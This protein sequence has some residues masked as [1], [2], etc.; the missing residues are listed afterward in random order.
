MK[1]RAQLS[2]AL[3]FVAARRLRLGALTRE[4]AGLEEGRPAT[5]AGGL[6]GGLPER[7]GTVAVR[8]DENGLPAP[9]KAHGG[10][11]LLREG[12]REEAGL[13]RG[14]RDA[15]PPLPEGLAVFAPAQESGDDS[16]GVLGI[17]VEGLDDVAQRGDCRSAP[18]SRSAS[19][20]P[21]CDI[22]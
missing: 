19:Q 17:L 11:A 15:A 9:A 6:A 5:A 3:V 8:R 10:A 21:G 7:L 2:R 20:A 22:L 12:G 13:G 14:P 16:D 1:R 4:A 18:E